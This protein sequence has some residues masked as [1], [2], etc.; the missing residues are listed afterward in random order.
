MKGIVFAG[1]ALVVAALVLVV[2]LTAP[3]SAPAPRPT[4]E[5][6]APKQRDAVARSAD[7]PAGPTPGALA[8]PA[9][10]PAVVPPKTGEAP[11]AGPRELPADPNARLRALEPLRQ[12]VFPG[13]A[14]LR[15]RL[16]HCDDHGA[17][18]LVTLESLEGG[19]RIVALRLEPRPGGDGADA[20]EEPAAD[21]RTVHCMRSALVGNVVGAPSARPG[22]RWEMPLEAAE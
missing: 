20:E 2:V 15:T 17:T 11:S 14:D 21:E 16:R 19:V 13:L 12:E 6:G 5:R 18:V 22:R 9:P 7:P 3:D 8:P 1:G 10:P 4:E